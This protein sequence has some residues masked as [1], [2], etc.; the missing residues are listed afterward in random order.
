MKFTRDGKFV[1]DFG[2]RPPAE[3]GD[4]AGEQPG[5]ELPHQQGPLP[6]RRGR[7]RAVHHSAEARA[8]VRR[9]HRRLQARLGRAR[10]AAQRDHERADCRLQ[11]DRRAA[12]RGEELRPRA[13]TSSRSRKDRRVYIGE[14]GQ[15]RIQVFTTEGKWLQDIYVS[16]N[17][18]ARGGCGGVANA[19]RGRPCGTTYKLA[20]S[21]DPQQKYLF[22][23]DGHNFVIW[24]ARSP[25]RQDARLLRRQRPARRP[26]ALPQRGRDRFAREHLHGRSRHR[27][28]DPEVRAGHGGPK[29]GESPPLVRR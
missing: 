26:A 8:R 21:K 9:V 25:E 1:W 13:C 17:T 10:D 22:V 20:I 23:A 11:V 4:D 15:N 16:P 29:V 27:Q 2:H 5:D 7:Q 14:R 19:S 3:A 12:A 28:A 18:P 24:I 6:A